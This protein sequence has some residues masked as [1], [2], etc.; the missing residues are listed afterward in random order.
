M[1]A[2]NTK[3]DARCGAKSASKP[4]ASAA[5]WIAFAKK[6][7]TQ[8]IG[9]SSARAMTPRCGYRWQR[10]AREGISRL[11]L[12]AM[13]AG[14]GRGEEGADFKKIGG[15]VGNLLRGIPGSALIGSG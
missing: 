7:N 11:R 10:A 2:Q 5:S 13:A 9:A 14:F 1:H 6:N 8:P 12:T 15:S 4:K 3:S